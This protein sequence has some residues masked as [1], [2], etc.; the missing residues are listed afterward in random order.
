MKVSEQDVQDKDVDSNCT[1]SSSL[2][3][4]R[5]EEIVQESGTSQRLKGYFCI[6]I[7]FNLS[8]KV[9][10]ETEIKVLERG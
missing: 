3:A 1:P 7:V 6:G 4:E 2:I 10:T 9:L 5:S 8:Q